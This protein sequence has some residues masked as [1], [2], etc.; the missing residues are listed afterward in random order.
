LSEL[1]EVN[2]ARRL[3]DREKLRPP[4]DVVAIA[5]KFARVEHLRLPV[6]VD[7]VCLNL[8]RR[9]HQPRILVNIAGRSKERIRFTLAH[10]LGHVIIPW[11]TGSIVDTIDIDHGRAD[12]HYATLEAEA[13]RFASELL[14]P[15]DWVKEKIEE[16][17]CPPDAIRHV[18]SSA[19]VS[20][21]AAMI[22]VHSCHGPGIVYAE[23]HNGFVVA[24]GRSSGTLA[25]PPQ[26]GTAID[27][28]S[29]FPWTPHRWEAKMIGT[30]RH[31]WWQFK[32][33][34]AL[35]SVDASQDWREL[36][37]E[38]ID[39]IKMPGDDVANFKFRI[40]GIISHANS[41]RKT[42]R[43]SAKIFEACLERLH[44]KAEEDSFIRLTIEHP[45][46]RRFLY[47]RVLAFMK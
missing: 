8:K 11:H 30:S 10:E 16:F 22:C 13:N 26:R 24:S 4:V 20:L 34:V 2:F 44:S 31:F 25:D 28:R 41:R 45:A 3:V 21:Q 17:T 40:N 1:P 39:D 38:I 15:A 35:P 47:A 9:G 6:D 36:L 29:L 27:P 46:F 42:D 5:R 23:I 7:G 37:D 18:A 12:L 33:D 32:G 14:M 43:T 19:E